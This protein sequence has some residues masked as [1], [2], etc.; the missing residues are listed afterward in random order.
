[1]V[2]A[3]DR[4]WLGTR[5]GLFRVDRGGGGWTVGEPA[6][7][8][9]AVSMVL[10]DP[11]GGALYAALALGHFGVKLHRS[12]DGG[13]SWTEL[14]A[15]AYPAADGGDGPSLELIWSLE[16]AGPDRP[17]ELWA[18]TIPGGLFHSADR[19][20]S[21]TLNRAL[22]DR[23]ER[24]EWFGGG[25]DHAGIH[26]V[27]VDPRDSR[28]VAVAVSCGGVWLTEDGGASWEPR[29]RGMVAGYAPPERREDPVMQDPHRMVRCAAAPDVFWVQH[30]SGIFRSADGAASWT[31]H[32]PR[33]PGSFG[34]AVAVH[35]RDPDTAWFAPALADEVRMPR[36]GRLVVTRTRDGGRSFEVLDRGLP[37]PPAYDLVYRHGLEVASDGRTLA[38]ASTTGGLWVSEDGGDSWAA[39]PA[40]LPPVACL[41]FG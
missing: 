27:S 9:Q 25:Y 19:G 14:P 20:L 6:F 11:R 31:M 36:D 2:D 33:G 22:W 28:R 40:R 4:F 26:S 34:F 39:V 17:G 30:H 32:E 24:A 8:G 38:M 29:T 23:P 10:P 37:A 18:G 41:R 35:P 1:M 5:K 16:A 13:R 21:W 7:P 3:A 15:P 12:D